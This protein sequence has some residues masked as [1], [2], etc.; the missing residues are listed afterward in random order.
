MTLI[1]FS[2]HTGAL[3][4]NLDSD[5]IGTHADD[6]AGGMPGR[7]AAHLAPFQHHDV[8]TPKAGQMP[9]DAGAD[10]AAADHNN[11]GICGDALSHVGKYRLMGLAR[12]IFILSL[13]RQ[14]QTHERR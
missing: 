5:R 1:E 2:D 9:G 8:R 6:I 12:E 14:V 10:D 11:T 3:G 7:A 4:I 13:A